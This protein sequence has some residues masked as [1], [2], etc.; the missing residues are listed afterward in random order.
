MK[1][2]FVVSLVLLTV[3]GALYS[4]EKK[5]SIYSRKADAPRTRRLPEECKITL[6]YYKAAA[7]AR[8]SVQPGNSVVARVVQT[9]SSAA[10]VAVLS[11]VAGF[12]ARNNEEEVPYKKVVFPKSGKGQLVKEKPAKHV[13]KNEDFSGKDMR[14]E[15][16]S[17]SN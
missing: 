7:E 1:K 9:N 15:Q 11:V 3:T 16:R 5:S 17:P 14:H 2:F 4:S 6:R 8:K 10:V 12:N 13:F